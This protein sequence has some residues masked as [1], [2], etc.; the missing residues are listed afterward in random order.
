MTNSEKCIM[1]NEIMGEGTE[2][3]NDEA[4]VK[5]V[6][7]LAKAFDWVNTNDLNA[8]HQRI[9]ELYRLGKR[10]SE[11]IYEVD[12]SLSTVNYAIRKYR[13]NQRKEVACG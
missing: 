6:E 4:K 3:M 13:L 5:E 9:I 12:V 11:I 1:I 7:A 10:P 2:W 8:N